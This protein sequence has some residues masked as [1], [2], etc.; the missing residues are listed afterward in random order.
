MGGVTFDWLGREWL[1]GT[2]GYE[3][4]SIKFPSSTS[5]SLTILAMSFATDNSNRTASSLY[6]VVTGV[7]SRSTVHLDNI[8]GSITQVD[9]RQYSRAFDS[10]G[11]YPPNHTVSSL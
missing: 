2:R 1:R 4:L 8:V 7:H 5:L 9:T 10:S 11:R 3:G 6:P